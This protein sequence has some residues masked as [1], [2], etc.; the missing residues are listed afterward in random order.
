[1]KH[2]CYTD[3][4]CKLNKALSV[5]FRPA[6]KETMREEL[7]DKSIEQ[8][9]E[10]AEELGVRTDLIRRALNAQNKQFKVR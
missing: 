1:M 4:G 3:K 2:W 10:Y 9:K 7:K 6:N 8:L 5:L